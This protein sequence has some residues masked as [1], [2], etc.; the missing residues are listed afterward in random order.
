MVIVLTA[1]TEDILSESDT[2]DGGEVLPGFT[3]PVKELFAGV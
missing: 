3:L 1:T 2:L